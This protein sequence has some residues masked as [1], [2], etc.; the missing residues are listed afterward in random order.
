MINMFTEQSFRLPDEGKKFTTKVWE[1]PFRE[2]H[3]DFK[4]IIMDKRYKKAERAI[5][6]SLMVPCQEKFL[7]QNESS[8]N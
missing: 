8:Q 2:D 1:M 4:A 6:R 7:F 3:E 5:C